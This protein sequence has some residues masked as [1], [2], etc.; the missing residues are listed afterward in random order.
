MHELKSPSETMFSYFDES[1]LQSRR[2]NL[3]VILYC[4]YMDCKNN[5]I[6]IFSF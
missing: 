6:A 1:K 2:D 5:S 4:Y 3:D